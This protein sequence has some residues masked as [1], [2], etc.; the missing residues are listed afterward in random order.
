MPE[1]DRNIQPMHWLQPLVP[2]TK[3]HNTRK[4]EDLSS[5]IPFSGGIEKHQRCY[6]DISLIGKALLTIKGSASRLD[7]TAQNFSE[8]KDVPFTWFLQ[9]FLR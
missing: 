9:A 6:S 5:G 4:L 1:P 2:Q 3:R 7:P 8:A